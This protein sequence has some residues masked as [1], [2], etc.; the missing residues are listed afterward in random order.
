[1]R[2]EEWVR[3]SISEALDAWDKE[4]FGKGQGKRAT[5]NTQE[6]PANA[7]VLTKRKEE[8]I[9]A[10]REKENWKKSAPNAS[11]RGKILILPKQ[12]R[13]SFFPEEGGKSKINENPAIQVGE[14]IRIIEKK[15]QRA[16]L[17]VAQKF[18]EK[19]K[20]IIAPKSQWDEKGKEKR[21]Q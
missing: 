11:R 19:G 12:K 14:R 15:G 4:R 17:A 6:T 10:P 9:T 8:Y 1:L 3:R 13:K 20:E 21:R 16:L 7:S 18:E 2:G 5:R